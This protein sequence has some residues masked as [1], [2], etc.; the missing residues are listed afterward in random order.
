MYSRKNCRKL[1]LYVLREKDID[2]IF[3][4]IIIIVQN[5]AIFKMFTF[6]TTLQNKHLLQIK[7]ISIL[8]PTN[9][10]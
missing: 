7:N 5:L 3:V 4:T 10:D 1:F 2:L 9:I 8:M 6:K